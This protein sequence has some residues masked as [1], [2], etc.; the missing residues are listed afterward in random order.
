MVR[1]AQ[2]RR[3]FQTV[4]GKP[5]TDGQGQPDRRDRR[6]G[7]GKGA[8]L[9]RGDPSS[10][11]RAPSFS[12]RAGQIQRPMAAAARRAA[13]WRAYDRD[14][15]RRA[16][17]S[18]RGPRDARRDGRDMSTQPLPLEGIRIVDF[19]AYWADPTYLIL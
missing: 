4:P 9:L 8:R 1:R 5:H 17:L 2:P 16:Q 3:D 7:T 18:G 11:G 6:D 10:G 13:A 12:R 19:T 15:I 14:S